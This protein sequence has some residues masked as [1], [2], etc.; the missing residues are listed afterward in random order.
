MEFVQIVIIYDLCVLYPTDPVEILK[1]EVEPMA[2][3]LIIACALF[4][5]LFSTNSVL[6][7]DEFEYLVRRRERASER[8][9]WELRHEIDTWT[10]ESANSEINALNGIGRLRKLN[11]SHPIKEGLSLFYFVRKPNVIYKY[12]GSR[13]FRWVHCCILFK[14]KYLDKNWIIDLSFNRRVNDQNQTVMSADMLPKDQYLHSIPSTVSM[15]VVPW[16]TLEYNRPYVL[17]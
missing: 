14:D 6:Y 5:E 15:Y 9:M 8:M 16:K 11:S 17:P 7:P 4:A 2:S 1:K 3:H 13:K 12:S 10:V